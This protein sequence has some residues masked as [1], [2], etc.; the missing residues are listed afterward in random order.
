M[1]I[2]DAYTLANDM[3]EAAEKARSEGL[4]QPD[5]DSVLRWFPAKR[6]VRVSTIHGLAGMAAF[7]ASTY[8]AYLGEGLGPLSGMTELKIPHPGRVSHRRGGHQTSSSPGAFK[9]CRL[10]A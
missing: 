9:P 10:Q 7:M 5:L 3:V 4:A 1:A 6:L 2:E 8:K